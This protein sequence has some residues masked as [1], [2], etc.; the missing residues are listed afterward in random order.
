M[1]DDIPFALDNVDDLYI[2]EAEKKSVSYIDNITYYIVIENYNEGSSF[3]MIKRISKEEINQYLYHLRK[4]N[5]D[6][7]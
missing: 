3:R 1:L 5:D 2:S 6:I 4:Y 7:K